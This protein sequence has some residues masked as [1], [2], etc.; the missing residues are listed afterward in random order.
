MIFVT[1]FTACCLSSDVCIHL[2]VLKMMH[3]HRHHQF[4]SKSEFI[5]VFS[6]EIC[7]SLC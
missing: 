4:Q 7:I 5:V 6:P 2:Y 1:S 3:L